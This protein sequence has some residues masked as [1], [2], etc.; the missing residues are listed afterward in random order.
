VTQDTHDWTSKLTF[1]AS[2][3]FGKLQSG[4]IISLSLSKSCSLIF[5]IS[6]GEN[7]LLRWFISIT[8]LLCFR[9]NSTRLLLGRFNK[10]IFFFGFNSIFFFSASLNFNLFILNFTCEIFKVFIFPVVSKIVT[11]LFLFLFLLF[12][13]GFGFWL[14]L[15]YNLLFSFF[16]LVFIILGHILLGFLLLFLVLLPVFFDNM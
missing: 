16:I 6:S 14:L 15:G 5:F 12:S 3:S 10:F 1:L 11:F 2:F 7:I 8:S 4:H 9:N 13:W